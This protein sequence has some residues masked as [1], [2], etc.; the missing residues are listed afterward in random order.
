[1]INKLIEEYLIKN[2]IENITISKSNRPDLCDYQSNDV[3]K[4]SKRVK[5]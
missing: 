5:T 4:I 2:G 1:M 3:F